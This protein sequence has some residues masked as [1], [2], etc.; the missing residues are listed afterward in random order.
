MY[1]GKTHRSVELV[2][3][4]ADILSFC[5]LCSSWLP[6]QILNYSFFHINYETHRLKDESEK[7][8]DEFRKTA[9]LLWYIVV[10]QSLVNHSLWPLKV[11]IHWVAATL[12]GPRLLGAGL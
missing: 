12:R 2:C 10:L 4:C 8:E 5:F 1:L 7:H 9:L 3:R 6:G 11:F